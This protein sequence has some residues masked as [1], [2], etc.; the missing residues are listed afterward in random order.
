MK[1]ETISISMDAEKLR[2]TKK[3]MKKKEL[4]IEQELA[5]ALQKLYEK[6]VPATVRDYIDE[7]V[8][9][10]SSAKKLIKHE[11]GEAPPIA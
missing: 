10:E 11:K 9:D 7:T 6:H 2:A 1:I 3:Y 8:D 5:D 4:F